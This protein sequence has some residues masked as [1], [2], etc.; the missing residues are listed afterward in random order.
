M[1]KEKEEETTSSTDEMEKAG[2]E[3][4]P[5]ESAEEGK[6]ATHTTTP[7]KQTG[8]KADV[9][10]PS[11]NIPGSRVANGGKGSPSDVHYAGKSFEPDFEKSPL[12][13]EFSK[14]MENMSSVIAKKLSDVEKSF[15]DRLANLQKSMKEIE[16]FE[17]KSFNKAYSEGV[18]QSPLERGMGEAM[19]KGQVRF[20]Q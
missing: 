8:Q 17:K 11:S 13:V 14:Q 9:F 6:T 5:Q 4:N 18:S 1:E 2:Y 15:N 16:D 10:V 12:Y 20:A 7:G 3:Q 19:K